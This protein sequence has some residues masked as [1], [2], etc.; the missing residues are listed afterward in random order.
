MD[1]LSSFSPIK[2]VSVMKGA[3]VGF[4]EAG[5]NWVG[6]IMDHAPGPTMMIQPTDM[7]AK[8]FSNQR[9][10]GLI[11]DSDAVQDRVSVQKSR[12][13]G[14]T[15]LL[16]EFDGGV[17]VL[18][19]A[20]SAAGLSSMPVQNLIL[21]EPDRYPIDL[22]GEGD[23]IK[24][25]EARTRT[26]ARRKIFRI[27]T[28]TVEGQ[29]QINLAYLE[30]DQRKYLVPCPFC[31]VKQEIVWERIKWENKDPATV[32]LECVDEKCKQ[33]IEEYHKPKMLAAGEWVAT[34][35]GKDLS[36]RSYHLNSLYSPL[37]WYSWKEAVKEFL[38]V[39]DNPVR[40]RVFVN[41]VLGLPWKQKGEA[42]EWRKLY[43]RREAY[44]FNKVPRRAPLLTAGVDIQKDRIEVEI[45][46]YGPDFESWSIDYRT[47]RGDTANLEVYKNL[48][49][50]LEES[51]QILDWA[52][53]SD[54]YKIQAMAIDTGFNTQT[55]YNWCRGKGSRIIPIKGLESGVTIVSR[56]TYVDV[57][58]E[59]K[60]HKRGLS[61]WTVS[62]NILKTELYGWLRAEIP[63][64]GESPPTG[65]CHF[66]Q[67]D[68][69][70]FKMLTAEQLTKKIIRGYPRY[71]WEKTNERNEALDA[72]CYARA[73]AY[74][75]GLDR[76]TEEHWELKT[77]KT[78]EE[79][80]K[81]V[82]NPE[83]RANV[84]EKGGVKFKRSGYL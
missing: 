31:G 70:Y 53:P 40:L 51:F 77:R 7:M 74:I 21:D 83:N 29:S 68:E 14:N 72:R 50:L 63:K 25:A 84:Y 73:A 58:V 26:F 62:T 28:P 38:E 61:L 54:F 39:K 15:M 64:Q 44:P 33:K 47:Y 1:S 32:Y 49:V 42:P 23:P 67:Y 57:N 17:L 43:D 18:V 6:Y 9:L 8:R 27:S 30:G 65:Y 12:D 45:V 4:S 24:L 56:P 13:S 37:G 11:A 22:P 82:K 34:K 41:T 46:A 80:K 5:L 79:E 69:G 59:G 81:D 66:P 52:H 60:V 71:V 2:E 36:V 20:N 19:G 55:I 3:Q 35:P 10:K 76:F 16:K 78:L 48:D 75:L